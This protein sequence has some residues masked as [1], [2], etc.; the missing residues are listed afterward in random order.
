MPKPKHKRRV[1][2]K[3]LKENVDHWT[4]CDIRGISSLCTFDIS[5]NARCEYSSTAWMT[6]LCIYMSL[7]GAS[8]IAD[9]GCK[10]LKFFRNLNRFFKIPNTPS[11]SFLTDSN[12]AL[13]CMVGEPGIAS[14]WGLTRHGQRRYQGTHHR[15][16]DRLP[17][18]FY[19]IHSHQHWLSKTWSSASHFFPTSPSRTVL[20]VLTMCCLLFLVPGWPTET[21]WMN[22][23]QL[24]TTS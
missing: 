12:F 8:T 11:I 23:W 14:L 9:C 22:L 3:Q 21:D 19:G 5:S 16:W 6:I 7:V 17:Y 24:H 2:K 10:T 1:A 13:H 15:K 18:E 20:S 4:T